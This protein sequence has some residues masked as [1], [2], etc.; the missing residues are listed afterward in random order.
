VDSDE[1][2]VKILKQHGIESYHDFDNVT[3]RLLKE[4][5]AQ[6]YEQG[7]LSSSISE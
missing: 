3:M 5:L 2:A 7:K 6:A 4:M 1:L